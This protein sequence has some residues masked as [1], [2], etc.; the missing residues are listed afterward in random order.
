MNK[1]TLN[2]IF[3]QYKI[4]AKVVGVRQGP[5][6]SRYEVELGRGAKLNDIKSIMGDI[7][8]IV[9][10]ENIQL[11][12]PLEKGLVGIDIPRDERE[13]V[14]FGE[15]FD[16]EILHA[17]LSTPIGKDMDGN[18]VTADL[19]KMP[20]LLVAGATGSGKSV[21]INTVI[22]SAIQKNTP[23]ELRM[24]LIDPKQ[25]ELSVYG[26]LPHLVRPIVTDPMVAGETLRDVVDE[27]DSRYALMSKHGVRNLAEFNA[28]V[29]N[30]T[31]EHDKLP[32][33]L[34]IIDELA[35]LMMVAR[36]EVEGSIVRITQL[37]RAAGMH[38][39]VATQRPSVDVITGLIK[40]NIPSRLAFAVASKTD[41]R[42]ILDQMG[43]EMLTGMGDSLFVPQGSRKPVRVQGAFISS[44]DVEQIVSGWEGYV[45]EEPE[46]EISPSLIRTVQT[47]ANNMQYVSI[48]MI[49]MLFNLSYK[50]A[51]AVFNSLDHRMLSYA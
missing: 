9:G 46:V 23:E 13:F 28:G 5:A 11:I 6:V 21:F 40:A 8:R 16:K 34:I 10:D 14:E 43:A 38:L 45:W 18:T 49:E 47:T 51:K 22:C 4:A 2:D 33:W 24:V 7:A 32:L 29:D 27:M 41:S 44:E 48:P 30:G 15:I 12:S 1:N 19:S 50:E 35:D 42:V 17:P 25:V 39:I 3:S 31:I 37:A 20:H 26:G 36:R